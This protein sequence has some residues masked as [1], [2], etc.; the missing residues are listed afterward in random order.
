MKVL[1]A[2]A[3]VLA[4]SMPVLAESEKEKDCRYQSEVAAAVQKAR[5]DGVREKN[6]AEEIAKTNPQWPERYNRAIP[7]LTAVV[8]DMRRRDLKD[9]D[10]GAQLLE[11][12]LLQ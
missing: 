12:C 9:N 1:I 3:C 6:I 7:I 5:L 8:F 2:V 4:S 10:V 11:M